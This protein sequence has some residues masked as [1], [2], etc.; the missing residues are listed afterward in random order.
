[1]KRTFVS[2]D[3][4]DTCLIRRCGRPEKIW[5]LMAERLFDKD[6]TRN[7]MSF[8]GNRSCVEGKLNYLG[9]NHP[10]LKDL[11]SEL[12]VE[13]WN[14]DVETVLNLE[15]TVEEEE[16]L[17]NPSILTII[18]DYR[19]RGYTISFISDMYLPSSFIKQILQKFSFC[20]E[21]EQVY[22]STE[23]KAGKF[24]GTLFDFIFEH[25][26]TKAKQWIHY[27]DNKTSDYLIP[28]SKGVKSFL[29]DNTDFTSEEKRWLS[30]AKFYPHKHEIELW[31][32]LCRVVRLQLSQCP[33]SA[34]AVD[35]IA[36][37]YVPYVFWI[38][39]VAE[40]RNLNRV[41]FLGRDGH[42][43]YEIA[44][45]VYKNF[46]NIEISYLKISRKAIYSC[47]FLEGNSYELDC[48]IGNSDGRTVEE[49]L[50]Q[51]SIQ[52]D[53]LSAETKKSFSR[54]TRLFKR[55]KLPLFLES[56][57][58]N[59]AILLK[60]NSSICRKKL[61]GYLNQEGVFSENLNV[62]FVDLGWLGSCRC[63]LNYILKKSNKHPI[64]TIYWGAYDSVIRGAED[65][66]LYVFLRSFGIKSKNA[67]IV[68][69]LM[70]HYA[71]MNGDGSTIGYEEKDGIFFAVEGPANERVA[72]LSEI[73][74]RAA[75]VVA[76]L[77][78]KLGKN[79]IA[80]DEIFLCC[81]M[82]QMEKIFENPSKD[83]VEF[84][85]FLEVENYGKKSKLIQR[86]GIK[87]F[88]AFCVWGMPASSIWQKASLLKTFGRFKSSFE[89]FFE[90]TKK[91]RLTT[92]F[93]LWWESRK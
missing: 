1:M 55:N 6:D 66:A 64:T 39:K 58:N 22:V 48:T 10:N 93:K 62:A 17:P 28:K 53:E 85:S 33:E 83:D 18:E 45:V 40:K 42:I 56:L 30:D 71:S 91:M 19:S 79:E 31:T 15:L 2:F 49:L 60:N 38:L 37:N 36:S 57:R 59:D 75:C 12:N 26:K 14:L 47:M 72:K 92:K 8:T 7:K 65:D 80:N 23:C 32:G 63:N 67:E 46:S 88:I 20:K 68:S 78:E 76:E 70:E 25:T 3:V 29:V 86:I 69:L 89:S 73:N 74:E 87:D 24:D 13:Q 44:K 84:F 54:D 77:Y 4:F 5:D 41:Y 51:I 82:K 27:G 21:N 90:I 11:Y 50:S 16:L 81:G 61:F 43:Y 52:Y 9:K 35:F 34:M